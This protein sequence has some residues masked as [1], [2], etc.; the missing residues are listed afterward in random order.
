MAKTLVDV[1]ESDLRA[2]KEILGTTTKR[3]TI[4]GALARVVAD[5]ERAEAIREE[6][7]RAM[8]GA[9]AALRD[10]EVDPGHE[11]ADGDRDQAGPARGRSGVGRGDIEDGQDGHVTAEHRLAGQHLCA[12]G[13]PSDGEGQGRRE[14]ANRERRGETDEDEDGRGAARVDHEEEEEEE[15]GDD[16]VEGERTTGN[17]ADPAIPCGTR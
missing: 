9:Y 5:A 13:Q 3:D 6:M 2:A 16:D 17:H 8:S 11:R 15:A 10:P 14:S 12:R 1:N 7:D 4:N